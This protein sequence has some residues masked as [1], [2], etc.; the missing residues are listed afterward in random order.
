MASER[1]TPCFP[2]QVSSAFMVSISN[3]AGIVPPYLMPGGRPIDFLCTDFSC[4]AR[5]FRI[6]EKQAEGKR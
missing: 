5:T 6:Q 3:R 2:A 4:L 1:V